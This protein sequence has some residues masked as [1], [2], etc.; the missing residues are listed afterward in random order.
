[1]CKP[2]VS[3]R[4]RARAIS[5]TDKV[6][7]YLKD[8]CCARCG[9]TD[10]IL[11]EF[12]HR[13]PALKEYTIAVMMSYSWDI[14]LT[15]IEK[16]DVMCANCHRVEHSAAGIGNPRPSRLLEK[17][18]TGIIL[19]C[20]HCLSSKDSSLFKSGSMCKT[21]H[22]ARV[23]VHRS[24]RVAE[25][26]SIKEAL[27]CHVC[28]CNIPSTLDFHHIDPSTKLFEVSHIATYG[29]NMVLAEIAKCNIICVNCH[30]KLH[31]ESKLNLKE[32][33]N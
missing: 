1:M 11:L 10:Y 28:G 27:G 17:E 26:A 14:I 18:L 7:E 13:D 19:S 24:S 25:L 22:N 33:S 20:K 29:W 15:E 30:R 4:S 5:S 23:R 3:L 32:V 16:C 9:E 2:C 8:K 31:Y 6:H 21:C 12:H